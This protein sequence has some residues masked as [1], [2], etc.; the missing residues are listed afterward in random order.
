MI[1][2]FK[3]FLRNLYISH[4]H[5]ERERDRERE[6]DGK[7]SIRSYY[8]ISCLLSCIDYFN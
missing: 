1:F 7:R 6:R 2:F 8:I 4:G 3:F 5:K